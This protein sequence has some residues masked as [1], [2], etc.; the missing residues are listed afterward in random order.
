MRRSV[1]VSRRRAQVF[2][3]DAPPE[4]QDVVDEFPVPRHRHHRRLDRGHRRGTGLRVG[5]G[6][7]DGGDAVAVHHGAG[8]ALG[9]NDMRLAVAVAGE[10]EVVR[11][12][13]ARQISFGRACS[14]PPSPRNGPPA[15]GRGR[16]RLPASDNSSAEKNRRRPSSSRSARVSRC[17][18]FRRCRCRFAWFGREGRTV[19]PIRSGSNPGIAGGREPRGGMEG[20]FAEIPF[21]RKL[22]LPPFSSP[23]HPIPPFPVSTPP[24]TSISWAS[25][26]PR[27]ARSPP[28]S[29]MPDTESRD[30]TARSTIR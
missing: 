11:L 16:N 12:D 27:W 15:S 10:C 13:R 1:R 20:V 4:R 9:G 28:P 26:A 23:L 7:G 29:A 14:R 8:S 21:S 2:E 19:R 6:D 22:P 25:A 18:N 17:G 24:S 30:P 5:R 3:N